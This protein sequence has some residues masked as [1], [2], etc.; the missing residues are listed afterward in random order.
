MNTLQNLAWFFK[1]HRRWLRTFPSRLFIP[2]SS[3]IP[4]TRWSFSSI[5]P[6]DSKMDL[7]FLYKFIFLKFDVPFIHDCEKLLLGVFPWYSIQLSPLF[8]IIISYVYVPSQTII[9]Y[10]MFVTILREEGRACVF[11][12]DVDYSILALVYLCDVPSCSCSG[13]IIF[14]LQTSSPSHPS[15]SRWLLVLQKCWLCSNILS[16]GLGDRHHTK[17]LMSVLWC[18]LVYPFRLS[19]RTVIRPVHLKY[20]FV[21]TVSLPC[22]F[23]L[24]LL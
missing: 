2:Q 10:S 5:F 22:F 6:T 9:W 1:S 3:I 23:K 12:V 24:I 11:H 4:F 21:K 15:G 8:E 18:I 20:M 13:W 19:H 7:L 16:I 17:T 14:H